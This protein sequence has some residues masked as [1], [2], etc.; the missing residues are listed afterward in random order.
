MSVCEASQ[1]IRISPVAVFIVMHGRTTALP[2]FWRAYSLLLLDHK[3]SAAISRRPAAA[4]P[5]GA[6]DRDSHTPLP[7]QPVRATRRPALSALSASPNDR[8]WPTSLYARS[9]TSLGLQLM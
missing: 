1:P 3:F 9:K 7:F 4:S 6:H 8:P 2:P 5:P